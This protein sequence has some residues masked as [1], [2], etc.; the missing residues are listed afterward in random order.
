M[1]NNIAIT[2]KE[3]LIMNNRT[4]VWYGDIYL[5]EECAQKAN[6]TVS[7]PLQMIQRILNALDKSSLFQKGYITSDISGR[8]R[9][10]RCYT[11]K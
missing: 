1:Q 7:H 8:T 3:I 2:M 5:L 6:I 9:R 10:Y 11:L 4:S